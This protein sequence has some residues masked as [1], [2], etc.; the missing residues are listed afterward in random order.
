MSG[1]TRRPRSALFRNVVARRAAEAFAAHA[2]EKEGFE[3]DDLIATYAKQAEAK[4]ARDKIA[5]KAAEKGVE[6]SDAAVQQ[7]VLDSV[8]AT[9]AAART[10]H[11]MAM[12]CS[13]CTGAHGWDLALRYEVTPDPGHRLRGRLRSELATDR[14]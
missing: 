9:A 7:A 14:S 8:R 6:I 12:G 10:G 5:A 13:I 3:A 4:G 1:T 2:I 11:A